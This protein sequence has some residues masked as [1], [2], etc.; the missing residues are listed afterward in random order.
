ML[1]ASIKVR[2]MVTPGVLAPQQRHHLLPATQPAAEWDWGA[3]G[4]CEL[5]RR[6][7]VRHDPRRAKGGASPRAAARPA[8]LGLAVVSLEVPPAFLPGPQILLTSAASQHQCLQRLLLNSSARSPN[9][10]SLHPPRPRLAWCMPRCRQLSA[11][12]GSGPIWLAHGGEVGERA[13]E[14]GKLPLE[15]QK[16][17]RSS[18]QG[19]EASCPMEITALRALTEGKAEHAHKD[20]WG[21][22]GAITQAKSRS[23]S[24]SS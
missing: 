23:I 14:L 16:A 2:P 6:R 21:L 22:M 17:A 12:R 24:T 5:R 3:D 19:G 20:L 8:P 11:W 18:R 13:H 4:S 15:A 10:E 1:I 7:G 9:D